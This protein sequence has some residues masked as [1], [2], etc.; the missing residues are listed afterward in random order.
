MTQRTE[1]W[2]D[3]V[4]GY[5]YS[6]SG[7]A[8]YSLL[9]VHG[10]GGH[11]GTY[12]TFCEPLAEKGVHIVSIDLP[13]HG[14]ARGERGIF[15]FEHWLEDIDTAAKEMKSRWDKPVFILGSSQG[16]AAAFRSLQ[17]SEHIAGAVTMCIMLSDIRPPAHD[18]LRKHWDAYNA[19]SASDLI[20]SF[21]DVLQLDIKRMVN[22]NQN[23]S[24]VEK[25]VLERKEA[26]PMRA[27]TYSFPS[28][29]SY[30][31]YKAEAPAAQNTKPVLV[32]FGEKG[33]MITMEYIKAC[34]EA[35]GGPK[36]L[37]I[38]EGGSHQLMLY[39]ADVYLP[40]VD[41]WIRQ[42]V[43]EVAVVC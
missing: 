37:E 34:Y 33:P 39:H 15:R 18:K 40:L 8:P 10:I 31:A 13:G 41:D 30:W 28:L 9:I 16:S 35:I 25:N 21:G 14:L 11:G 32:T 12:D 22:W 1:F 29:E 43:S 2:A 36:Q 26:H 4:H 5:E 20:E 42:Q 6:T 3:E 24:S 23:Y 17:F 7:S 19:D 38:I 27:W